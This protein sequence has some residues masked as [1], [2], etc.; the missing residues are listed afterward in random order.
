MSSPENINI[1]S[2][3]HYSIEAK[4]PLDAIEI[5]SIHLYFGSLQKREDPQFASSTQP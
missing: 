3:C 1:L 5:N 2:A 4:V